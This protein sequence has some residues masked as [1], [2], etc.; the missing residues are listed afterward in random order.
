MHLTALRE[1]QLPYKSVPRA[2]GKS[3]KLRGYC[4]ESPHYSLGFVGWGC[5]NDRCIGNWSFFLF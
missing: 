3:F 5:A 2:W 4:C 1:G